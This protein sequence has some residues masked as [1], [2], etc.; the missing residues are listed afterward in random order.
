MDIEELTARLSDQS[1][2]PVHLWQPDYC[3]EMDLEIRKDG[4]WHYMGSPIERKKL[5]K[6]FST[7]LRLD[8]D[9]EYYLVTPVEKLRIRVKDAPFLAVE[10]DIVGAS[11]S[12]RQIVF[13]TN[14]DDIVAA[15][16]KHPIHVRLDGD[17]DEPRPYVHVRSGLN[18]LIGRSVFYQLVD[19]ATVVQN[20]GGERLTVTSNG[21]EFD[22]GG[23]S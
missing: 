19:S 13:R 22:L 20:E 5:V 2:P 21:V 14:V 23:I 10:M 7:V 4:S 11:A 12:D 8:D 18:A 17:D 1:Y 3:A 6:L 9:G 15:G 16:Q